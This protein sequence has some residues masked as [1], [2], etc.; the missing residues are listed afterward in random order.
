MMLLDGPSQF[1][2]VE[3]WQA[4]RKRLELLNPHD[5]TVAA[6]IR[7]ADKIIERL[8]TPVSGDLPEPPP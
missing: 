1:A 4:W 7:R 5:R 8:T 3:T 2:P 6:E